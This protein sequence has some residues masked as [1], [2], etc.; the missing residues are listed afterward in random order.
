LSTDQTHTKF[1]LLFVE[2]GA[3]NCAL[4]L[5]LH[6]SGLLLGKT[7]A[8]IES[9]N[10]STDDRTLCYLTAEDD[11]S[12]LN[13]ETLV[14]HHLD[15]IE[16]NR[17]NK[18]QIKPL[19]FSFGEDAD[20]YSKTKSILKIADAT[21]F[22]SEIKEKSENAK[23]ISESHSG[24]VKSTKVMSP[25]QEKTNIPAENSILSSLPKRAFIEASIKDF[26]NRFTALPVLV[27]PFVFTIL[28]VILSQNN[29]EN[30]SSS[31]L[32]LGFLSFGLSH[33]ALDHLTF[34]KIDNKNQLF[35]FVARYILKSA[36]F[37]LLWMFLPDIAL[38]IFIAYSAWHFG[39]ADFEEWG[40]HQGWQSFLWGFIALMVILIFHFE[41]LKW[42]LQQIP[43][44]QAVHFL[45]KMSETQQ[46][47]LQGFILVCG[48]CLAAVN[49]SKYILLTL[50]YLLL[51][52][53]LPLLISFGIYFVGQHSIHG[54]RHLLI[55]LN[56]RSS[57]LWL[58][59]LPFSIGGAFIILCIPYFA[60]QHYVGI[61]FILLSCLSI[62]HV[63]SMHRFYAKLK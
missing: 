9:S 51:S 28:T 49:K 60:G 35:N 55:A 31:I 16:S 57:R 4:I 37:G 25:L 6:N 13:L 38:L 47:T 54:W 10:K 27:L 2:L 20:L 15:C 61:F 26:L 36:I 19:H 8:I 32:I 46:A 48:F 21:F 63:I 33:G 45:K 41:E 50:A 7:I 30:I 34:N 22:S 44:L 42:I 3:A 11:H 14:S 40:L 58:K 39:Q 56:E 17:T 1:D 62:P 18:Q 29:Y 23:T 43:N 52:S 5:M 12:I 59:S 53:M 24:K